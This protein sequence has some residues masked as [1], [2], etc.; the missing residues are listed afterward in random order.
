MREITYE[1][2]ECFYQKIKEMENR[3]Q[4]RMTKNMLADY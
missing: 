3:Y 4:G 1:H 2:G